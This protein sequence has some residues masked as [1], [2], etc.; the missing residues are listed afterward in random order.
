MHLRKQRSG[1]GAFLCNVGDLFRWQPGTSCDFSLPVP[2]EI[3]Q[4]NNTRKV[5]SADIPMAEARDFRCQAETVDDLVNRPLPSDHTSIRIAIQKLAPGAHDPGAV[6]AWLTER[7]VFCL[8]L[9]QLHNEHVDPEDAFLA[10][11]D[12]IMLV[13]LPRARAHSDLSR[14]TPTT[15]GA[16]L[17]IAATTVKAYRDRHLDTLVRSVGTWTKIRYGH[18]R[19]HN[20]RR[21]RS[22]RGWP[23]TWK[24]YRKGGCGSQS[25]MV[26][27]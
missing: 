25:T 7:P 15:H 24:H 6:Q 16:K 27:D 26:T 21:L 12:F 17:L 11:A 13:R 22:H 9:D 3:A 20:L 10:L 8:I 19:M 14:A 5:V 2:M 18:I 4:P 1:G 23:H